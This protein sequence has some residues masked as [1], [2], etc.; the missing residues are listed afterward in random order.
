MRPW[1][2]RASTPSGASHAVVAGAAVESPGLDGVGPL[3]G[4]GAAYR[5]DLPA[6]SLLPSL[7]VQSATSD[8]AGVPFS[9]D[10]VAVGLAVLGTFELGLGVLLFGPEVRWLGMR[11]RFTGDAGAGLPDRQAWTLGYGTCAALEVPLG[12]SWSLN[13]SA[14]LD[15]VRLDV[16]GE[17]A[18]HRPRVRMGLGLGWGTW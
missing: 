3:W 7:T 12:A 13:L 14:A 5:L 11:Q 4:A 1:C 16:L 17:G 2:A 10:E 8:G 15:M 9:H 18:V 6:L